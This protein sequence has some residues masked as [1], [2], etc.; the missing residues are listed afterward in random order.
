MTPKTRTHLKT[1]GVTAFIVGFY[2]LVFVYPKIIYTIHIA[3]TVLA[4]CAILYYCV[5]DF[6]KEDEPNG[7]M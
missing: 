1:T 2:S 4:V 3:F 7:P 5:Y 6:F